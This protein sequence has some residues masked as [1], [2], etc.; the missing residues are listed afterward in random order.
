MKTVYP[1]VLLLLVACYQKKEPALRVAAAANV[2]LATNELAR[3]FTAKHGIAVETIAASSGK[4]TAQILAGAPYDVF[5]SADLKYPQKVMEAGLSQEN[6]QVYAEGQLVWWCLDSAITAPEA[7]LRGAG[8]VAIAN[9]NVAP[10]GRAAIQI[11]QNH[12]VLDHFMPRM[13]Y[14]ENISQV[15]QFVM[16]GA[17]SYALTSLSTVQ[18][19]GGR[20]WLV[21]QELHDPIQQG[22]IVV[23]SDRITYEAGLSFRKFILSDQGQSILKRHGYLISEKIGQ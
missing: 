12:G 5:L 16:S 10:Y 22:I 6:P 13:V 18:E 17:A 15:N 20:W 1:F 8:K 19:L 3:A 14:G 2:Q 23:K 9:P 11:L 4:I 7:M 21:P